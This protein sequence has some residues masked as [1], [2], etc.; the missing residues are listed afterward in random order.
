MEWKKRNGKQYILKV[1]L[2]KH[3]KWDA[4]LWAFIVPPDVTAFGEERWLDDFRSHPGVGACSWH[5]GGFV[6]LPGQPK[7][8]DLQGLPANVVILNL[9]K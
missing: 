1:F 2:G 5:F 3:D 8:C 6:P 7:I 4:L 9:F